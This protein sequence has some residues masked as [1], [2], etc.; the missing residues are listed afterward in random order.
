MYFY[1]HIGF[2]KITR[3]MNPPGKSPQEISIHDL[4]QTFLFDTYDE[5]IEFC[6]HCGLKIINTDTK[7]IY[8]NNSY[9]NSNK[10]NNNYKLTLQKSLVVL[11]N[12]QNI[13]NLMPR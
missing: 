8:N 11:I 13:D 10:S 12:G 4:Q 7:E 6:L 3:A 1:I 2:K 9:Y 5:T